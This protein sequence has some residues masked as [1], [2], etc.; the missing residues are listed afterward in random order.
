MAPSRVSVTCC[1]DAPEMSR[2]SRRRRQK[3]PGRRD[4]FRDPRKRVL[5]VCEG[6]VTEPEY[7]S[8]FADHCRNPLL[9]VEISELR[10][11]PMTVV[12]IATR[13][14]TKADNDARSRKDPF[15]AYDSV[16]CVFDVDEHPFLDKARETARENGLDVAVSNPC[17][18][19]WLLL[20]FDESPGEQHRGVVQ[21][22]LASF[23]PGNGKHVDFSA[24]KKGYF[25]AV[26]RA[27]RLEI[28]A[29][30]AGEPG[31]NP[32]TG[33]FRLTESIRL[34]AD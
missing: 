8:A 25:H 31:R 20:H 14:K 12:E 22:M 9:Q 7:L 2:S 33:V 3:R 30:E 26:E 10:G 27:E 6:K 24:L 13:L 19:L 29:V 21:K 34:F 1:A 4:P 18:E 28:A 16:W 11:V 32:T 23:V 15:L 17:F 5:V